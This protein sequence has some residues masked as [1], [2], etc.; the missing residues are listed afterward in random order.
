MRF[1]FPHL[2]AD[3][4][5]PTPEGPRPERTASPAYPRVAR[6]HQN[7]RGAQPGRATGQHRFDH[8][9]PWLDSD[10][11]AASGMHGALKCHQIREFGSDRRMSA[12][13]EDHSY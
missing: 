2:P 6:P 9:H 4:E 3:F 7:A 8:L 10:N 11:S 12:Y 13:N 5:I 1:A